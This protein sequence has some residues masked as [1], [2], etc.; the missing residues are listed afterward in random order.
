M[1]SRVNRRAI[2]EP[3]QRQH[4]ALSL[5]PYRQLT[6]IRRLRKFQLRAVGRKR[7]VYGRIFSVLRQAVRSCRLAESHERWRQRL[8]GGEDDALG[9]RGKRY[10]VAIELREQ[11]EQ[12]RRSLCQSG[13]TR[14][15]RIVGTTQPDDD[16]VPAV[17]PGGPCIAIAV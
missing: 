10:A 11:I 15:R 12:E 2:D 7:N 3:C 8:I 17:K 1:M 5:Q 16:N 13:Q 4:A 9:R 14:R 6:T